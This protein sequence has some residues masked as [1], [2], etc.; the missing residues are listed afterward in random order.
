MCQAL[1]QVLDTKLNKGVL[2][3]EDLALGPCV[4]SVDREVRTGTKG[5]SD[6][7][8]AQGRFLRFPQGS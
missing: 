4:I 2:A 6:T 1:I 3:T 8:G 5:H 7:L